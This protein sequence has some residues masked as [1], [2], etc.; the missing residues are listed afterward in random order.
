MDVVWLK[1]IYFSRPLFEWTNRRP[2]LS[3][4][5]E[6]L[7]RHLYVDYTTRA[8]ARRRRARQ[9]DREKKNEK[10]NCPFESKHQNFLLHIQKLER[11]VEFLRSTCHQVRSTIFLA[12]SYPISWSMPVAARETIW[13]HGR[14]SNMAVDRFQSVRSG[15]AVA[16]PVAVR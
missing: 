10:R 9:R 16:V 3:D 12:F 13:V 6:Q 15:M 14:S 5:L 11:D 8:L 7:R 4:E 2:T 1:S